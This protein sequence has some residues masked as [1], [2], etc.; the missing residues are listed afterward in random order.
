MWST[1]IAERL[2]MTAPP[3]DSTVRVVGRVA[4]P[5]GVHGELVVDVRTDSPQERFAVGVVF[6]AELPDGRLRSHPGAAARPH[7]GRLLVVFEGVSGR[8][9]A[10]DLRGTLLRADVGLLPPIDD[11]DEFYDHE[12]EGLAAVLA[13]GA[14][15][16]IVREVLHGPAG[17]L[18]VV[19]REGGGEVLVPFVRDIVPEVD[20]VAGRLLVTPPPGLIEGV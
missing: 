9:A 6:A 10:E 16:G 19:E 11:P 13:D 20:V 17:E 1:P 8:A 4:K 14:S 15:I 2:S 3:G 12:L 18:L 7:A 5:H